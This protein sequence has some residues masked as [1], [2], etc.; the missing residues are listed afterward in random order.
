MGLIEEHEVVQESWFKWSPVSHNKLRQA[1]KKIFSVLK[2][3]YRGCYVDIGPAV[4]N[5]DKIW[6]ISVNEHCPGTPLVMLHGMGSGSALWVLNLDTIAKQRPVYCIDLLGF[7]RSS[8]PNF[9]TDPEVA[10]KQMV[11][12]IEAWRHEVRLNDM[13]LLGHSLGAFLATSYSISYPDRVKHLI[14]ADPWGFPERPNDVL[15][16][17]VSLPIWVKAIAFVVSPLNPLWAVRASGPLGPWL[18]QKA[19]PDIMRKFAPVLGDDTSIVG[20]YIYQCN[21]QSPTG[22]SAFHAMMT[23]F[24][25]AK[26][27]M[28]NRIQHLREDVPMSILYGSRSWVDNAAGEIIRSKRPE[29]SYLNVQIISG[30]GHHV[31]ADRCEIFNRIV[32]ETV[33]RSSRP[34]TIEEPLQAQEED[35]EEKTESDKKER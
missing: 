1:E 6:T 8:R 9:S 17:K 23:G 26:R 14:L 25:W 13:I 10:E 4:G 21:A 24:G 15:S 11:Q 18:I 31:Y 32:I 2:T 34:F 33:D 27:P 20:Q 16:N 29:G 30:A 7:A 5:E 3:E 12:A 19:R 35:E 22:E 28:L